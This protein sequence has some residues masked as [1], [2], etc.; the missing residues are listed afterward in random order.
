MPKTF[1]FQDQ[2]PSLPAPDLA[3]TC[4]VY[5]RSLKPLLTDEEFEHSQAVVADFAR[6]GATGRVRARSPAPW[7][8][9]A[10]LPVRPSVRANRR[11]GA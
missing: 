10:G 3:E 11:P 6:E 2:L 9:I 7:R 5:L 4:E 8:D 1:E